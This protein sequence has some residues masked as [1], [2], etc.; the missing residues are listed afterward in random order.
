MPPD[1]EEE[2]LK[3][4]FLG[5]ALVVAFTLFQFLHLQ[6][7][8]VQTFPCSSHSLP[9]VPILN[10]FFSLFA[11]TVLRSLPTSL[12]FILQTSFIAAG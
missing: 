4:P 1:F 5:C 6:L 12:Y 2:I 9:L 3:G 7:H 11:A 8:P 10:T